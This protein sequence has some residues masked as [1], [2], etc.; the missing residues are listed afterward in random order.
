VQRELL[1]ELAAGARCARTLRG[2]PEPDG[3]HRSGQGVYTHASVAAQNRQ[4]ELQGRRRSAFAGAWWGFGF[5]EDGIRSGFAAA[6][7]LLASLS[8][9][10]AA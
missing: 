1:H 10:T 3:R 6:D 4:A 9:R 5:H 2:H 7:G 8:A